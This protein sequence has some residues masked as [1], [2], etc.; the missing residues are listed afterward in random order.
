MD[1]T[2]SSADLPTPDMYTTADGIERP[3]IGRYWRKVSQLLTLDRQL[4]FPLLY[5]LMIGL[6]T[7]PA[8]NADADTVKTGVFSYT[9]SGVYRNTFVHWGV[10]LHS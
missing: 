8:T 5:K 7:I 9:L 3:Q 6:M 4:R 1:Y 2:L 10:L